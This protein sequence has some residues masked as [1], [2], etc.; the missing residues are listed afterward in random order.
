MRLRTEPHFF[1]QTTS[2]SVEQVLETDFGRVG[3]DIVGQAGPDRRFLLMVF[4]FAEG[5]DFAVVEDNGW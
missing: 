4:F 2:V 1:L 5:I 3:P